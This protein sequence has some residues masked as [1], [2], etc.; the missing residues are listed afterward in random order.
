MLSATP[1]I[2]LQRADP[3]YATRATSNQVLFLLARYGVGIT[4]AE[5]AAAALS[6]GVDINALAGYSWFHIEALEKARLLS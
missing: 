6:E 2:D 3:E 1:N 5:Y 4:P